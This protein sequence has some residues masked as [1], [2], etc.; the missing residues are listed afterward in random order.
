MNIT[1]KQL[2]TLL[3]WVLR[4]NDDGLPN[5]IRE[6]YTDGEWVDI[7]GKYIE[8]KRIPTSSSHMYQCDACC[9]EFE[10]L[11]P[12]LEYLSSAE[13]KARSERFKEKLRQQIKCLTFFK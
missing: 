7:M 11:L 2:D 1:D 3:G 10:K 4:G 12:T 9:T 13:G 5:E 6:C 8:N